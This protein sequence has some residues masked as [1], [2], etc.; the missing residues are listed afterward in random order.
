[1]SFDRAARRCRRCAP[2]AREALIV[3]RSAAGRRSVGSQS[4]NEAIDASSILISTRSSRSSEASYSTG[5]C[6]RLLRF[7]HVAPFR[8]QKPP[9]RPTTPQIH[10]CGMC[11]YA[12]LLVANTGYIGSSRRR[13]SACAQR[14]IP[15]RAGLRP[16]ETLIR[17]GRDIQIQN[18]KGRGVTPW[19]DIHFSCGLRCFCRVLRSN[20]GELRPNARG[21]SLIVRGFCG[22]RPFRGARPPHETSAIVSRERLASDPASRRRRD[23]RRKEPDY[24]EAG[25]FRSAAL[26]RRSVCRRPPAARFRS[27][28][29]SRRRSVA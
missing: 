3:F 21:P 25:R 11:S 26:L 23:T 18:R 17:R 20:N 29:S 9:C 24:A 16:H 6:S 7:I 2:P 27:P 5:S 22:V 14:R 1:M 10:Q 4:P 13:S 28:I 8:R 19:P 12:A 15:S